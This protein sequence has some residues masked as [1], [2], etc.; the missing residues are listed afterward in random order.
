MPVFASVSS[1]YSRNDEVI[2]T[3]LKKQSVCKKYL[4]FVN[5]KQSCLLRLRFNHLY[6]KPLLNSVVAQ[7]CVS[8]DLVHIAEVSQ[9][10]IRK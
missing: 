4:T 10:H 5:T 2:S 1:F 8:R 6:N 7:G 3:Y 9:G